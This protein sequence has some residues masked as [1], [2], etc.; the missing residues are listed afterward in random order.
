MTDLSP[1]RI[2]A[3]ASPVHRL[4]LLLPDQLHLSYLGAAGLDRASDAV[5]QMELADDFERVPSHKQRMALFL[6]AMRHFEGELKRDGWRSVYLRFDDPANDGGLRVQLARMWQAMRPRRLTFFRPGDFVT[7]ESIEAAATELGIDTEMLEDPHFLVEPE[8]F[9]GWA[10]GRKSLVMEHFYRWSRRRLGSLMTEDG[11][12]EGGSWNY[13]SENRERLGDD[14]PQPPARFRCEPD[15]LTREVLALV[16]ERFPSAPGALGGFAWP[17]TR[18]QALE[19]LDDFITHRLPWFGTYQDAMKVGEPWLFHSL[20]SPAL[21]LKLL[22]PRECVERAEVAYQSGAAPLN[23]VEG[24]VRQ[25]VGWREFIRGVYWLEGP[26]YAAKNHLGA[27]H[28]LPDSYWTGASEMKCVAE[29]VGQVL[30]HGYGHHIQRLM[31]TGN[32]ALV[33]GFEPRQVNDWYLGMFVDAVDWVTLPNTLGMTLYADGGVVGS[34]PYAA[35]GRYIERMSD[36]CSACPYEPGRRTG[37]SACPVTV[38]YWD[39]LDRHRERLATLPRMGFSLK[40]LESLT[41][42]E[43]EAIR[44]RASELRREWHTEPGEP[45]G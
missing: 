38:F 39:F 21:N 42:A 36:Y 20:L 22:D 4:L 18:A 45:A 12:P 32:L 24:F 16:E 23:S 34:K 14:A 15:D 10:A 9:A 2:D 41:E 6:S 35:S 27:T 28:P 44:H 25:I 13:D 1:T 30:E 7:L 17:T 19:A 3:N 26:A 8:A 31:V 11:K 40:N 5:L 37:E 33:A 29:A 43:L